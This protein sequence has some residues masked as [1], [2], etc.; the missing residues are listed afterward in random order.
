MNGATLIFGFRKHFAYGL[1]HTKALVANY[2]FD[3]VQ[4]AATQPLEEADPAGLVF[5]HALGCTKNFTVAIL[6]HRN[7]NQNSHIF[8]LSTPASA[9]VDPI[10]VNIWIMPALQR[11]VAPILDVDVCFLIQLTDGGGRYL[12]APEGL[13]DIL[14]TPDRYASQVHLDEGFFHA[15][16]PTAILLDDS[17]FKGDSFEFRY[18]EGNISGSGGEITAVMAA[19][20]ALTLLIAL[21][22]G[23]LGQSLCLSFQQLVEGLLYAASHKF[24]DLP[25]DYFFV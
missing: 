14:N 13:S 1:Q 17:C 23:R 3:T 4:A 6:I 11:S 19:A 24:L 16:F 21:I 9:Q 8:K 25:L 2:Q 18:F 20:G 15:A 12:A 10:H 5:F 7:R 22:P